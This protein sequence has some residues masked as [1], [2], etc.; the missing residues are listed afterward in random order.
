MS[1]FFLYPSSPLSPCQCQI[2]QTIF[3][4]HMPYNL[5]C[6]VLISPINFLSTPA[7]WSKCQSQI[8]IH[9]ALHHLL[10]CVDD[11]SR[12]KLQDVSDDTGADYINANYM[13][14]YNS[15]R[16]F[17]AAQGPLP[18]T[19]DDM[20]Q[21]IWEQQSSIIVMLTQ[22]VEKGR[23]SMRQGGVQ[24]LIVALGPQK[25]CYVAISRPT[26]K[27]EKTG[28]VFFLLK[29]SDLGEEFAQIC[30]QWLKKALVYAFW[31]HSGR[32]FP[33]LKL[34]KNKLSH[35]TLKKK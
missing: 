25:N 32:V 8:I 12:I 7:L 15:P 1:V 11:H 10:F 30:I 26:V 19:V 31:L 21:M 2:F 4:N 6:L 5:I 24:F 29:M 34:F 22:L 20:W 9:S 3:S 14:G 28:S 16:E 17:L 27:C 18:G 33:I 35:G 23:V 13:P